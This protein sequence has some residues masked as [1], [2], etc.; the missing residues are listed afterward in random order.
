MRRVRSRLSSVQKNIEETGRLGE[1]ASD[2]IDRDQKTRK[3]TRPSVIA[4]DRE[5]VA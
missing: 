5:K 4:L 1:P 3:A 2:V